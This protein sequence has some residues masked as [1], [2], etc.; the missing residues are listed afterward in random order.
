MMSTSPPKTSKLKKTIQF[1]TEYLN[2]NGKPAKYHK[3]T[4]R[5]F[6]ASTVMIGKGA[7]VELREAVNHGENVGVDCSGL[8]SQII[9]SQIPIKTV[10][11]PSGLSLVDRLRFV[12]RPIE[13]TNVKLFIQPVNSLPITSVVEA[14]AMDLINI[15]SNHIML[16]ISTNDEI[17][18]INSSEFKGRVAIG[19][20]K[21]MQPEKGLKEQSWS[22]KKYYERFIKTP[23]SGIRR[24]RKLKS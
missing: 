19:K 12:L 6:L 5:M 11:T 22:D 7:P 15:G 10:I 4:S 21:I 24:L 13:N 14:K 1:A 9:N 20:I 8:V 18:Y 3:Q 2:I 23:G 17:E 16:I